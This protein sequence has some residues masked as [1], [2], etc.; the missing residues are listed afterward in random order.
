[1]QQLLLRGEHHDVSALPASNNGAQDDVFSGQELAFERVRAEH[2]ILDV[3]GHAAC[4][5]AGS[6]FDVASEAGQTV[7]RTPTS[8]ASRYLPVQRAPE[9]FPAMIPPRRELKPV[10][11]PLKLFPS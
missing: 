4:E 3:A 5:T 9:I 10:N 7:R 6:G 11:Q 2:A 8:A 1:M